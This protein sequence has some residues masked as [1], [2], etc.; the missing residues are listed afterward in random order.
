MALIPR[1]I[2]PRRLLRSFR[3]EGLSP[4]QRFFTSQRSALPPM[5]LNSPS[6]AEI[7][8]VNRLRDTGSNPPDPSQPGFPYD[9]P[10][11]LS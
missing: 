7:Q 4:A 10:F 3:A 11:D 1:L 9:F 6:A 5:L 2:R 8:S